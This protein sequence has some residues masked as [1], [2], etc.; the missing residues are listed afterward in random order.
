MSVD[1]LINTALLTM[2]AAVALLVLGNGLNALVIGF[3]LLT[4]GAVALS[5]AAVDANDRAQ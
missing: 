4:V 3:V 5:V 2:S 1:A